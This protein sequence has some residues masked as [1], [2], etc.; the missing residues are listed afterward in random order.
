MNMYF[1]TVVGSEGLIPC[2]GVYTGGSGCKVYAGSSSQSLGDDRGKLGA[3]CN[4]VLVLMPKNAIAP[5]NED[6][7]DERKLVPY[8]AWGYGSPKPTENGIAVM[9]RWNKR[10]EP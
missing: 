4:E 8:V 5:P 6:R 9:G 7:D 1:A 3:A 2:G 10:N